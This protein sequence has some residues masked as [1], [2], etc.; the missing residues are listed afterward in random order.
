[1]RFAIRLFESDS[2]IRTIQELLGQRD[3][4]TTMYPHAC[5]QPMAR[6]C[7]QSAGREVSPFKAEC[8]AGPHNNP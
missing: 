2:D 1:M 5:A 3:A 7:S 4:K 6:G 8:Y